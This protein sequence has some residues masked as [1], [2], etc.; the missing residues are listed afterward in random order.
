MGIMKKKLILAGIIISIIAA[1][2]ILKDRY[3][4]VRVALHSNK[5]GISIKF[6]YG[7]QITYPANTDANLFRIQ[8]DA[9]S[10]GEITGNIKEISV[11]LNKNSGAGQLI[12]TQEDFDRYYM[13]KNNDTATDTGIIK[14]QNETVG[15]VKAVRLAE[16]DVFKTSSEYGFFSETVWA[17]KNNTNYYINM[18]GNGSISKT[19][20]EKFDEIL[21]SFKFD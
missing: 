11:T 16:M 19:D 18:M 10:K 3:L 13:V 15:G 5:A 1:G 21:K 8:A 6:P 7:W 20:I 14:V 17:R 4:K 9:S 12:A 2:W